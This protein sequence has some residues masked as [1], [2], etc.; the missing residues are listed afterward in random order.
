MSQSSPSDKHC[1]TPRTDDKA[2]CLPIYGPPD[3]E[4][5]PA[6]FAR[7][8]ERE[9]IEVT[10]VCDIEIRQR[11]KLERDLAEMTRRFFSSDPADLPV[12]PSS[13]ATASK[14]RDAAL[15]EAAQIALRRT[16]IPRDARNPTRDQVVIVGEEIAALIRSKKILPPSATSFALPK[17]DAVVLV[18]KKSI[19]LS[20]FGDVTP[21]D[22]KA[23]FEAWIA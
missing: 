14:V 5:V 4:F 1:D 17:P 23:A 22:A 21:E 16:E 9:L 18:G 13:T 20:Y 15:E 11:M 19:Q 12:A 3:S 10:E 7:Q 2:E 8:L 6:E